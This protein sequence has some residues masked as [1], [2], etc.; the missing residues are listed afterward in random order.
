VLV[1]FFVLFPPLGNQDT[2]T[3]QMGLFDGALH[4]ARLAAAPRAAVLC[5][6]ALTALLAI[7][8]SPLALA[9]TVT[10]ALVL[11]A[12]PVAWDKYALPLVAALWLLASR[13]DESIC[14]ARLEPLRPYS[15]Q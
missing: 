15:G 9:L 2:A 3:V 5:A 12:A 10:N 13:R 11:L 1:V 14:R 8:R 4:A 6:A 7:G